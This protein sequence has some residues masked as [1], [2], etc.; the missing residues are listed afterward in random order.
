MD[1]EGPID[2]VGGASSSIHHLLNIRYYCFGDS[3]A[4]PVRSAIS[5]SI[6]MHHRISLSP[7]HRGV[8]D[9]D[10]RTMR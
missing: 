6:E 4:F 10:G 9:L 1:P 8:L 3:T 2:T 7:G 5:P